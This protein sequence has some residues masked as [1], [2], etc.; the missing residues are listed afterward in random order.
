[1][2]VNVVS[3]FE[4]FLDKQTPEDWAQAVKNL[5]PSIHEVDRAATEIWFAFFPLSLARALE[6]AEDPEQLARKLLLQGKYQLKDQIDSSHQFLYGH[7]YWPVVKRGVEE[8]ASSYQANE[9]SDL[10][11]EIREVARRIA[12]GAGAQESLLTGMTAIAL[13]T[14]RQVGLNGFKAAPGAMLIDQK[15][16][17]KTTEQVLSERARDDGQGLFGFLRTIDKVWTVTFDENDPEARYKLINSQ[18]LAWAAAQDKRDYTSRDARRIEGPVPVECRNAACGTCWVGVVGGAEKLHEVSSREAQKMKEFG[19][20]NTDEQKPLIRLACI[21]PCYGAVSIVIPPW[22]G[23]FGKFLAA[24]SR[25]QE[26]TE[27]EPVA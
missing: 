25:T 24:Q 27:P 26:E 23:V 22:N 12:T 5:L 10:T 14:I 17:R 3:P 9:N 15:H 11:S 21:T 16:A 1:M 4:A 13:M 7:R 18:D 2:S 8:Y 19:Y 6:R 20:I